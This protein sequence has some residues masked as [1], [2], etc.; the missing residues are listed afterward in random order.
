MVG[1]T[2]AGVVGRGG[3][4]EGL[5]MVAAPERGGAEEVEGAGG[6]CA[7]HGLEGL[8]WGGLGHQAAHTARASK[9]PKVSPTAAHR[10]GRS[11][12]H[13]AGWHDACNTQRQTLLTQPR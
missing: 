2:R 10:V 13:W 12:P 9:T 3:A 11:T 6:L 4:R 7:I 5:V 1:P 8:Q